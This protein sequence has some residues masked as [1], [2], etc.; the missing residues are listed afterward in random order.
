MLHEFL[1]GGWMTFLAVRNVL[2]FLRLKMSYI[3]HQQTG[4]ASYITISSIKRLQDSDV[5]S[6]SRADKTMSRIP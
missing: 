5:N 1:N 4:G 2:C 3:R 6:L